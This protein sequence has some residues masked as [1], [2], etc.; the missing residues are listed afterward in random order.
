MLMPTA[1]ADIALGAAVAAV[2]LYVRRRA[3]VR[4]GWRRVRG[5]VVATRVHFS[6]VATDFLSASDAALGVSYRYQVGGA[7]Y[8]G[9][10]TA[11]RPH[12]VAGD[13]NEA[14]AIA[15]AHPPGSGV[16]VYYDPVHPQRSTLEPPDR[17]SAGIAALVCGGAAVLGGLIALFTHG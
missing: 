1:L 4:A 11:F 6:D 5:E 9:D 10:T 14:A 2:G 17:A 15:A 3:D 8:E 12:S 16:P 13:P 7:T